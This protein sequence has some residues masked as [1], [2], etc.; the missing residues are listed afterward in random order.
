MSVHAAGLSEP[1]HG[2]VWESL[3][4]SDFAS[5]AAPSF[6]RRKI[7]ESLREYA[8]AGAL[9]LDHLAT[10]PTSKTNEHA[11]ALA[12]FGLARTLQL[13]QADVEARLLRLLRQ[14]A[15]EWGNFV[16]SLGAGSFIA[17]WAVGARS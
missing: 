4:A 13:E 15:K 14:H 2:Y 7:T 1:S 9:H 16:S 3:A 6:P 11:L 17:P 5:G 12:A 10:L 8:I